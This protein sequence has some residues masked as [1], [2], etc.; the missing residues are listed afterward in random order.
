MTDLSTATLSVPLTVPAGRP[1]ELSFDL[2]YDTEPASDY[3]HLEA[4]RDDGQTWSA[5]PFR[6][7]GAGIDQRTDGSVSGYQGRQWLRAI[8]DLSGWRGPVRL[9]WRYAT[10]LLYH[11]RGV[12]VDS[13]RVRSGRAVIFDGERGRDATAF[14]TTGW[15]RSPN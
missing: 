4:S 12:Y 8:A 13:V 11:G 1:A 3:L 5:V 15:V 7:R 10:D 2:Y 14:D 6:I 9:R